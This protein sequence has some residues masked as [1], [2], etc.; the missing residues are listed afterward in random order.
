MKHQLK[1]LTSLHSGYTF[2]KKLVGDPNGDTHVIQFRDA[3]NFER[4]NPA[5]PLK[6][7]GSGMPKQHFLTNRDVI[8]L[9]KGQYNYAIP[10]LNEFSKAVATSTFVVLRLK[11]EHLNPAYLAWY[12]NQPP[13]QNFL[14]TRTAGTYVQNITKKDLGELE[15]PVPNPEMQ[16]S[17]VTIH[18][19]QRKYDKLSEELRDKQQKITQQQLLNTLK[20]S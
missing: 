16:N 11:N 3:E 8:F 15:I 17:I 4:I 7:D 19:L 10:Y 1:N 13:A 2:R 20:T 18:N 12:L 9:A 5:T 6:I 14:K